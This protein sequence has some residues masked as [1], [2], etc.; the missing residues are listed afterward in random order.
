M[1]S[2]GT[3]DTTYMNDPMSGAFAEMVVS[4]STTTWHDYLV[5]DGHL[6]AE[7]F[8]TGNAKSWDWFVLDHLGSVA[9]ITASDGAGSFVLVQRVS[10][11]AWGRTRNAD[12]TDDNT[13]SLPAASPTTRGYT[14]QEEMPA[15]CL[16]NYNAR[17][18][19]PTLGRFLSPDSVTQNV[20]DMQLLNRYT[21]VGNNPLSFTDP[22]GH[23][24][25][26]DDF[27]IAF[28]LVAILAPELHQIPIL[29]SLATI[30]AGFGCGPLGPICAGIIAA[31]V[32]GIQGGTMAQAF[33]AFVLTAVEAVAFKAIGLQSTWSTAGKALASGLVGGI[34][35]VAGGGHFASGF[36]AAGFASFAAPSVAQI[37]SQIGGTLVSAVLGGVGS[38]LGG[39][40]F[41]NGAVTGAFAYAVQ[42]AAE[43]DEKLFLTRSNDRMDGPEIPAAQREKII[44][45]NIATYRGM[46]G[47]AAGQI[48]INDYNTYYVVDESG[49]YFRSF[50]NLA[51]TDAFI[52][53]QLDSH[54]VQYNHV[55]GATKGPIT[56]LYAESAYPIDNIYGDPIN[57]KFA[58]LFTIWHEAG[59]VPW[60]FGGGGCGLDEACAN[61]YGYQHYLNP[62]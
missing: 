5:A 17:I 14:S 4:G 59:H 6:V 33:K 21:Y 28:V 15:V 41:A 48:I 20:Y 12:G 16:I 10:Y 39:G 34:A 13:C 57:P 27:F 50:D 18:Y 62:H 45:A 55:G 24:F 19:D 60:I 7:R 51:D 29:G 52:K 36:L 58:T 11:D 8:K 49:Q 56:W 35:S 47:N 1:Q 44:D 26:I 9:V 61:N 37:N 25:G 22:T 32:T 3:S 42:S 30:L 43:D 2:S 53:D 46:S 54:G 40:K 23:L 31:E 38:V